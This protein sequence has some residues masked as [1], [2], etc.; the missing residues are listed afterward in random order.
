MSDGRMT[1][2]RVR[3]PDDEAACMRKLKLLET[4]VVGE[5]QKQASR[6]DDIRE[7]AHWRTHDNH[8]VDMV[9][10]TNDGSVIG[11]E[12]KAR[13]QTTT[14]DL[15]GLRLLRELLGD[16][17]RAGFVLTTGQHSGRIDDRIFS[18]P[19]DQLWHTHSR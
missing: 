15:T 11:F 5:L 19:I 12:V 9:I 14:K 3:R 8:E 18:I 4:F 16:Q 6:N 13:S 17:F 2:R 7:V 10:E 1:K